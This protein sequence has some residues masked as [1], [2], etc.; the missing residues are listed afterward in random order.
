MSISGATDAATVEQ[1]QLKRISFRFKA[2][3]APAAS[4]PQTR[5]QHSQRLNKALSARGFRDIETN[6]EASAMGPQA[7]LS[8]H[9][10]VA[11]PAWTWVQDCLDKR[12]NNCLKTDSELFSLF[13]KVSRGHNSAYFAAQVLFV[14]SYIFYSLFFLHPM[15]TPQNHFVE[16]KVVPTE[17]HIRIEA[18]EYNT[19]LAEQAALRERVVVLE[20][21][22]K[23][24]RTENS[25]LRVQVQSL[26]DDVA[27]LRADVRRLTLALSCCTCNALG[28]AQLDDEAAVN[29][30]SAAAAK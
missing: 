1:S 26:H 10:N 20:H 11:Q 14:D 9:A 30:G 12:N 7:I 22:N 4:S 24:L 18:S 23:Y 3:V 29:V 13:Q 19:V 15:R 27:A 21:D 25:E 8:L 6:A 5:L 17:T 2:D 16:V 28:R